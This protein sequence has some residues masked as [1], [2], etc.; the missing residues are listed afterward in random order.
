MPGDDFG[1]PAIHLSKTVY[2]CVPALFY[3]PFNEIFEKCK[4]PIENS[5]AQVCLVQHRGLGMVRLGKSGWSALFLKSANPGLSGLAFI[6]FANASRPR[7]VVLMMQ[8]HE[9]LM[10]TPGHSR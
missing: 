6:A 10:E 9:R 2:D 8:L 1:L 4:L 5:A 3:L 7:M